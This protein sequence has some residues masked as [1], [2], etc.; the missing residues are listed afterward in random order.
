MCAW[1]PRARTWNKLGSADVGF[2]LSGNKFELHALSHTFTLTVGQR[3][4]MDR[5]GLRLV[6]AGRRLG[7]RP[8]FTCGRADEYRPVH[9]SRLPQGC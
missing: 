4:P 7:R 8:A 6:A 5:A 2:S 9:L 1:N 3:D